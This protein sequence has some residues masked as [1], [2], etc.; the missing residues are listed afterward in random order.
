[1][2]AQLGIEPFDGGKKTEV[3]SDEDHRKL[4]FALHLQIA[5]RAKQTLEIAMHVRKN[6]DFDVVVFY[7]LEPDLDIV[8]GGESLSARRGQNKARREQ[9]QCE[10]KNGLQDH[11]PIYAT[12]YRP[13]MTTIYGIR[14]KSSA[15]VAG[16]SN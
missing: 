11:E 3:A 12:R 16:P 14:S 2:R 10:K 4:S 13:S 1:M 9:C 5:D 8:F 7:E 15:P 6:G